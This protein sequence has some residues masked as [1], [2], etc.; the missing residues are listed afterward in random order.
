MAKFTERKEYEVVE[1]DWDTV[2]MKI[3]AFPPI[4]ATIVYGSTFLIEICSLIFS[5][6]YDLAIVRFVGHIPLL[7]LCTATQNLAGLFLGKLAGVQFVVSPFPLDQ[8]TMVSLLDNLPAINHQ[9][10]IG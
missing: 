10:D 5:Q 1:D 2:P 8:L 4:V 7:L 6:A 3:A 9:D